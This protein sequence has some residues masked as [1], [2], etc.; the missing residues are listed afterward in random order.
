MYS[1]IKTHKEN[2]PT[3]VVRSGCRTAIEFVSVFLENYLYKE[4][5]KK[6]PIMKDFPDVLNIIDNFNNRNIITKDSIFVSFDVV[7]VLPSIN[8]VLGLEAASETLHNRESDFPPAENIL[9]TLKCNNYVFNNNFYSQVDVKAMG[10]R[11]SC[12]YSHKTMY[13]FD[14]IALNC[15]AKFLCCKRFRGDVFVLWN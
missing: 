11:M 3:R 4:V 9:G 7:N 2:N 14:L 8:D 10:P 13:K 6:D 12:S 5:N 1:L 15:K